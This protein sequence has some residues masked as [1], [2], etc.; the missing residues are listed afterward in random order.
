[1]PRIAN[2]AAEWFAE[3]AFEN[4]RRIVRPW[5]AA[6]SCLGPQNAERLFNQPISRDIN[7]RERDREE[8]ASAYRIESTAFE[9]V[10]ATLDV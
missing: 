10:I 3:L 8:N 6:G 9:A 5:S 1:M 7:S 4:A 2:R